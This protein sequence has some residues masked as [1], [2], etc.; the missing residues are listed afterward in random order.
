MHIYNNL[1]YESLINMHTKKKLAH[2]ISALAAA[3]FLTPTLSQAQNDWSLEEIVV[4]AQKRAESVNDVGITVNAF[5]GEQMK[6]LGITNATDMAQHTPGMTLSETAPTGVPVYTIRGMGF[7]DYSVASNSTVGVYV[8]EVALP[9][10]VMTGG[11]IFDVERIEVLKGAQGDLYGRN[12]TGGAINFVTN[13]PSD[14]F[15]AGVS[16]DYGRY[17]YTK[18]EGHITGALND[19]MQGR[20]AFT[21]TQQDKGI[22]QHLATGEE[23]GE[24]DKT[25]LRALLNWD[26][27]EDVSVLLDLH[28]A[29]DKSDNWAQQAANTI[30]VFGGTLVPIDPAE[31][32]ARSPRDAAWSIKPEKDQNSVGGS[33]TVNWDINDTLALTS[34]TAYDQFERDDTSDWDGTSLRDLDILN[35]TE[36]DSFSQELRLSAEGDGYSWIAGVYFSTDTVDEIYHGWNGDSA[37]SFG[38][39]AEVENRYE[40]DT[41]T[42]ALFGHAEFDL[43]EKWRLSLGARYTYEKRDWEGCTHDVDGGLATLYEIFGVRKSGDV[44]FVQGDCVTVDGFGGFINGSGFLEV[45]NTPF[46]DEMVTE[47]VSGKVT[48]DYAATDDILI[49]GTVGTGFK[50]GGYNGAFAND[51]AQLAPYQEEETLSAELGFKAT[52]LDSTMQL[53]GA[54]FYYD[55]RD[56][57]VIDAATTLFGP[58]TTTVNVPRSEIEGAELEMQWRPIQGLDLK[59]GVAYLDTV[60]EEFNTMTPILTALT[61]A[62]GAELPNTAQWQYNGLIGYEFPVADGL[63]LRTVTDFSYSDSYYTLMEGSLGKVDDWQVEDYWL[64]NARLA[65]AAEDGTWEVAL[66]SRNL[67]DKHYYSSRSFGNGTVNQAAGPGNTY[68]LSVSYNWF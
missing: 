52:L 51:I 54:F 48:L 42:R 6:E 14:E 45:D 46:K 9:Y 40:Q 44:S 31:L 53:N 65:L 68:G 18:L 43:N 4:T 39:F 60:V 26:V 27:N 66:W 16:F 67:A 8:N 61:D 56:K 21:T 12:S 64:I 62:E 17:D 23:L 34:I 32:N 13:K 28:T 3:T 11:Q 47:N 19:S 5:S 55:Y 36:I 57:Q 58:L 1:K 59:L 63:L 24:K 33:V 10:P 49:Y 37:S 41:D 25:A 35:E 29:Q 50:S 38:L 15:G 2:Q 20:I 22:Q 7:D 30:G